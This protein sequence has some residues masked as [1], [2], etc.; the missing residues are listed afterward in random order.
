MLSVFWIVGLLIV[1]ERLVFF[2]G[3]MGFIH[4]IRAALD[5]SDIS[6]D[7]VRRIKLLN[8]LYSTCGLGTSEI[9]RGD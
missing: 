8:Y 4:E 9:K 6:L 3:L 2:R 7:S 1:L 5:I